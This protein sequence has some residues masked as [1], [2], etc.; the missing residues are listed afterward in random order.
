MV[1]VNGQITTGWSRDVTIKNLFLYNLRDDKTRI[2]VFLPIVSLPLGVTMRGP[3]PVL[4]PATMSLLK[5][6]RGLGPPRTCPATSGR[7]QDT[8]RPGARGR[9]ALQRCANNDSEASGLSHCY[10]SLYSCRGVCAAVPG[11]SPPPSPPHTHTTTMHL[12]GGE[13]ERA[14]A[15]GARSWQ[16]SV[17]SPE[18]LHSLCLLVRTKS[19]KHISDSVNNVRSS[20]SQQCRVRD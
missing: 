12:A 7:A 15:A 10:R 1:N 19:C 5:Q 13:A 9:R 20:D 18:D 4:E 6:P 3:L 16:E 14:R 2:V 11:D 8:A 17:T